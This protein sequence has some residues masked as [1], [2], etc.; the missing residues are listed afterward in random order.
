M[1]KNN[2]IVVGYEIPN[3]FKDALAPFEDILEIKIEE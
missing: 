3:R 2:E 1:L